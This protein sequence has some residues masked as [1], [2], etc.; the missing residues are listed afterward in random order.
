M[1]TNSIKYLKAVSLLSAAVLLAACDGDDGINGVDGKDGANF[2][3]PAPAFVGKNLNDAGVEAPGNCTLT[4]NVWFPPNGANPGTF[5]GWVGHPCPQPHPGG[6]STFFGSAQ[7]TI[8]TAVPVAGGD[9]VPV[10]TLVVTPEGQF[11]AQSPFDEPPGSNFLNTVNSNL[12]DF[13]GNEM[14]NTQ[15]SALGDSTYML[16]DGQVIKTAIDEENPSQ[17]L[18]KVIDILTVAEAGG[19]V[20]QDAVQMGLDILEGNYIPGKAYSGFPMLH[21]NGPNKIGVVEPIYNEDGV[22]IG[23]N[24]NV[25]MIY[26]DQH[27]ESNVA[28]VDPSAVQN[29]P[30]TVTYNVN[31]LSGGMEDFSPMVMNFDVAPN[32]SRG[33]FHAS[34]DQS[35]FPM[36]EEGNRYTVKIKETQGKYF[37]LTYTWGWRIHPPRVQVMENALKLAGGKTLV[38]HEVD[39]FGI[40]P[41]GG[42]SQKVAAISMIGDLSPAK[43]MWNLLKAYQNTGSTTTED[44]VPV[45]PPAVIAGTAVNLRE[46]W[47]DWQD[48]TK[49]PAGV[50]ADPTATIT[51]LFVNNTIYGSKQGDTGT[52]DSGD[53]SGQ[54]PAAFKGICNGCAH[55]WNKRPYIYNVTLLNGDHFPHGYMN[56]DFGGSRGWENQYQDTDPTTALALHPHTGQTTILGSRTQL[57]DDV[58]LDT[59]T[60]TGKQALAVVPDGL[61]SV[62]VLN[63]DTVE[64]VVAGATVVTNDRVFPMN[65]GGMEEFLRSSPRGLTEDGTINDNAAQQFGSGCFFTF[66]RHHAWPNAGGPWG[67]IIVPPYGAMTANQ[68]SQHKVQIEYNFEPSRRLKIYQFD[69][70]HHDVAVYSLH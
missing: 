18:R 16:H 30:W 32:G 13:L 39:V 7:S 63:G 21:Y 36:L 62:E 17:A 48:R 45:T 26:W 27:I 9:P 65:S 4:E 10:E 68:P 38:A 59:T 8:A 23:G 12:Y 5:T 3:D 52:G 56:V 14:E 34:M 28:L 57:V 22:K 2:D 47:L 58:L 51:L 33:P 50:T 41:M 61:G 11:A 1:K 31:I 20:D 55:D 24:V 19:S 44:Q 37:N 40:N 70:L 25:D 60:N 54:G 35:Y 49:L 69:P 67:A 46:A 66:G 42:E 15:P 53:D 29:V 43:R 6:G 64:T